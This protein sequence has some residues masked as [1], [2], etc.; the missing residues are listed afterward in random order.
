MLT[1]SSV[2]AR[3]PLG[4]RGLSRESAGGMQGASLC[5][6]VGGLGP[7]PHPCGAV[8]GCCLEASP[9]RTEVTQR[10]LRGW[11]LQNEA[12]GPQTSGVHNTGTIRLV[13]RVS[14][15]QGKGKRLLSNAYL[16]KFYY[17]NLLNFQGMIHTYNQIIYK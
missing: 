4:W 3:V 5:G 11:G 7:A 12:S 13:Q 1:P 17:Q 9:S 6:R 15:N 10:L 2:S 14:G 16:P 8:C